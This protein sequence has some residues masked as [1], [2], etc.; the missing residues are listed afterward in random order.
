MFHFIKVIKTERCLT[1][2]IRAREPSAIQFVESI[3]TIFDNY[4]TGI[5]TKTNIQ[6]YELRL[7]T[8]FKTI[9]LNISSKSMDLSASL[10]CKTKGLASA[11]RAFIYF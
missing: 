3:L 1:Q 9:E 7:I 5:V 2:L 10:Y 6:I 4:N 8:D 11:T